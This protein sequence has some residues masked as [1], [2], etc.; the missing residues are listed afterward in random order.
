MSWYFAG[1]NINGPGLAYVMLISEVKHLGVIDRLIKLF[2]AFPDYF[3][4]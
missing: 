1:V 3:F 2:V 4:F